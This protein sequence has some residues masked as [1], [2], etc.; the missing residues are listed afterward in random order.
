[1][2]S[3][4]LRREGALQ[5]KGLLAPD[6]HWTQ[7]K[8]LPYL[9]EFQNKM[10]A[11][12]FDSRIFEAYQYP[13][14]AD[15]QKNALARDHIEQDKTYEHAE[16]LVKIDEAGFLATPRASA[17]QPLGAVQRSEEASTAELCRPPRPRCRGHRGRGVKATTAGLGVHASTAEV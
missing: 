7:G 5:E 14:L 17:D 10:I 11:C 12:G 16:Y 2:H 1:M 9:P 3:Q 15:L 8:V 13:E 4:N 6:S